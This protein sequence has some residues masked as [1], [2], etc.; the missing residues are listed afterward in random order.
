MPRPDVRRI[1]ILNEPNYALNSS[2]LPMDATEKNSLQNHPFLKH[3]EIVY[4]TPTRALG[5]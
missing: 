1:A 2:D 5:T 3:N 4:T